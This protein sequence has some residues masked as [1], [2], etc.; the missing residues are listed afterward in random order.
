[1]KITE[2]IAGEKILD[3]NSGLRVFRRDMVLE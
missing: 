1:M 3:F 2:L